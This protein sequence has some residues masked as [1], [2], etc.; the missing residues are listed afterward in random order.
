MVRVGNTRPYRGA[1]SAILR[2]AL[3]GMLQT[4]A[5]GVVRMIEYLDAPSMA[6]LYE[7][8]ILNYYQREDS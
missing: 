7:E 4:E 3:K 5:S 1:V 6:R 8:F 2:I